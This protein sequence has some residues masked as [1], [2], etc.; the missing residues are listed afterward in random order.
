M[1]ISLSASTFSFAGINQHFS[2]A[3][4]ALSTGRGVITLGGGAIFAKDVG[5]SKDFTIIDPVEDEF[6]NYTAASSSQTRAFFSSFIGGEWSLNPAYAMQFG[7]GFNQAESMSVKGSL[8]QGPDLQSADTWTYNYSVLTRQLLVESKFIYQQSK[9]IH[10]YGEVGI[11]ASFNKAENYETNVPFDI[12]FT[13][14]YPSNTQTA[15]TYLI[16]AGVEMDIAPHVRLGV[17]YRFIDAGK[18][19]LGTPA[20]IDVTSVSG[21]LSTKHLYANELLA[22]LSWLF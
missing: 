2:S 6:Y 17:G 3:Y 8:L 9:Y 22:Q 12:T 4:D 15:F 10:P 11:G 20:L 13:R 21:T 1:A 14:Q 19:Q 5:K 18:F 16:G 7:L